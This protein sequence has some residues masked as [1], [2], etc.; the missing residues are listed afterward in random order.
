MKQQIIDLW[1]KSF[2]DSDEFIDLF[3]NR[4]YQAENTLTIKQNKQIIAAL[5]I[6]PYE[7][8]YHNTQIPV[9]YICGVCTTP[10]ERGKGW[11][12]QLMQQAIDEMRHRSYALSVLI[13]ASTW[14]FDYYRQFEYT[15]V[16]DYS[17]EI[18]TY[19][20]SY[21]GGVQIIPLTESLF[22]LSYDYYNR[23]QLKR[24][25]TILHSAYD[26]E[27]ILKDCRL[28][29]GNVWI[30]RQDDIITGL[31]FAIPTNSNQI[32]FKEI[33]YDSLTEKT[34]L[35]QSVLDY[36]QAKTASVRIPPT[37][38]KSTPYGM[39]RI[40]DKEILTQHF[41]SSEIHSGTNK[42]QDADNR[43]FTQSIFQYNQ[44]KAFMNLMLD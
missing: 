32:F 14:L 21:K 25:C 11:M 8:T 28:D 19:N 20:S 36:Y 5:Q 43:M 40:L 12:K 16:F 39:A 22:D 2:D 29:G 17:E 42:M 33:V 30:V 6:I 31:T 24:D 3:F 15:T 26:F 41:L 38:T 44:R 7:M 18:Y 13:P 9:G 27:T 4:V 23:M 34:N 35:I 10:S 37:P 1:K